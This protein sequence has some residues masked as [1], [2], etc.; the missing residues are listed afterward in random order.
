MTD[1]IPHQSSCCLILTDGCL[2]KLDLRSLKTTLVALRKDE[3]AGEM[4]LGG[5]D[6]RRERST[7]SG[8][9][10]KPLISS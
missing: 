2:L 3:K 1:T 7:F 8:V 5:G 10:M 4:K 9:Q 6:I